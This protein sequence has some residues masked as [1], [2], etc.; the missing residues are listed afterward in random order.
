MRLINN[1]RINNLFLLKLTS[2]ISSMFP[3][4]LYLLLNYYKDYN[5]A[6]NL[7]P[8]NIIIYIIIVIILLS[9]IYVVYFFKI[10][11]KSNRHNRANYSFKN[12]VQERTNTSSYLL[13]NV[14]PVI[15]LETDSIKNILF[16]I[17]LLVL[18]GFMYIKNDLYFINP[19]FDILNIKVYQAEVYE[20]DNTNSN[21]Q[22][23]YIISTKYIYENVI[24]PY[25]GIKIN[26][27]VII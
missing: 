12:L 17:A 9:C 7:I 25:K 11:I 16:L 5:L 18:L 13:S 2:F 6:F 3:F 24:D 20:N 14:L 19:L 10:S 4:G 15:T 27:I 21:K 1:F 8:I 26:N 22:V 23:T